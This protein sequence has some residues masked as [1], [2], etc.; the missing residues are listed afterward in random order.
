MHGR[1]RGCCDEFTRSHVAHYTWSVRSGQLETG[2]LM[3]KK[4]PED[5]LKD[6]A[7]RRIIK[8]PNRT[9]CEACRRDLGTPLALLQHIRTEHPA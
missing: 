8:R 3:P 6:A 9:Y 4:K 7:R 1:L 2:S 5:E